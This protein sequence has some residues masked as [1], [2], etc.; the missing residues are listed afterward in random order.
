M[1]IDVTGCRAVIIR[2]GMPLHSWLL[3]QT[4]KPYCLINGSLYENSK[5]IGTVI[6]NGKM[7]NNAGGGYG[8]GIVDGK[9]DFGGPW[10]KAWTDYYTGYNSPVQNGK[11]V[12]PGWDDG[13]VFRYA[14][15]RIGIGRRNGKIY[16]M[17]ADN[18]TVKGFADQAISEGFDT[19]VNN[20]GGGSRYLYANGVTYYDSA[21]T[22]YNAIAFYKG[23]TPKQEPVKEDA[24]KRNLFLFCLGDDVKWLQRK[25]NE[26]GA[27][28]V[29]DGIFGFGTWSALKDYQRSVGLDADG[30]AGPM[31]YA[32]FN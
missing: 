18:V 8:F 4:T 21:R 11:Y 22:P 2:P 25:L 24:P 9:M 30:I 28:L 5:V 3:N 27:K 1:L 23:E 7:V 32:S 13:Y 29:V 12:A 15:P 19:L 17:T 20:D 16:A 31:T 26:H 14:L 10:D 6:E